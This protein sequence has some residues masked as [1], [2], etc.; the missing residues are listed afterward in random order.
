MCRGM[1]QN[2]VIS[3]SHILCFSL[4]ISIF[5]LGIIFVACKFLYDCMCFL[6]PST[7][8]CG[9]L[10]STLFTLKLMIQYNRLTV[11]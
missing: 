2:E 7:T 10:C 3:S 4:L 1:L 5:Q 11:P 6:Y 8:L 9:I